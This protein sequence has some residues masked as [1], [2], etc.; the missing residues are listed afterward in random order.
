MKYLSVREAQ[1]IDRRAQDEFHIPS[2]VLME[3][4]GKAV[5]DEAKRWGRSFVVVAGFGHNGGDGLVAARH[6]HNRGCAVEILSLQPLEGTQAKMVEALKIPAY[7]E[8]RDVRGS[9]IIDAL[10]GIG[11]NRDVAGPA[12]ELI[13]QINASKKKVVAV[14][15]PSGLDGD[16]G[17]PRGCAVRAKITV[18]MGFA[19][20]GFKNRSA[21]EYIGRCVVADI[22]YPREL[23]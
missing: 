8:F 7:R 1:E 5:A 15:I 13:E 4:A 20:R 18:T 23:G 16:T 10:F 9:V 17:R 14:D 19:K 21:K 22:G 2:I 11:L 6:L 3:H 12:A